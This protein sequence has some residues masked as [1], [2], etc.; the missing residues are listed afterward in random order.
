MSRILFFLAA[1]ILP[2]IFSWWL[3]VP[4][5]LLFIYLAKLPYEVII[6]GFILDSV[7]YFGNGFFARY[8]LTIFSLTFIVITFF[9][10]KKIH[11]S[12]II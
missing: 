5:A 11:W 7:Y 1:I 4:I 2:I 10:S 6:A 9:L 8:P 12:E 3:F